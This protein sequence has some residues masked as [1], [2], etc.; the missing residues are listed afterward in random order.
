M[1]VT[2]EPIRILLV[3]DNPGDA[4]VLQDMLG[5][6]PEPGCT[7]ASRGS[8][9][10]AQRYLHTEPVDV[11]LLDLGL[12]DAYGFEAL[13]GIEDLIRGTPVVV[14][15]ALEDERVTRKA[16]ELGAQD[17]LVKGRFDADLLFRSIRYAMDR[18]RGVL[19]TQV[20]TFVEAQTSKFLEACPIGMVM[21]GPEGRIQEANPAFMELL[22][23]T[24]E[25]VE[26]GTLHWETLVVEADREGHAKALGEIQAGRGHATWEVGLL[27]KDGG[28]LPMQL[29]G[30]RLE[31]PSAGTVAYVMPS[32]ERPDPPALEACQDPVTGLKSREA[33]ME[34]LGP[35]MASSHRYG[36]PLS[37]G[38]YDLDG[39]KD[40]NTRYGQPVGDEVLRGL[41]AVLSRGI[42]GADVA[43]RYGGDEFCVLFPHSSASQASHGLERIQAASAGTVFLGP[44]GTSFTVTATFGLVDL[45]SGIKTPE[46]LFQLADQ[47]LDRAKDAGRNK[48]ESGS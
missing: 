43:A 17:F 9:S 48:V 38:L 34:I 11:V 7:L 30:A 20:R 33:F 26:A 46:R 42:R 24:P 37:L 35:A 18:Q 31:D 21:A 16:L 45:S 4:R 2:S 1:K 40:I 14:I 44:Q 25:D 23:Y 12:P 32:R 39:F 19:E 36:H 29:G 5:G 41:A 27:T 47:A 10:A 15:T 3:E 22:G 28:V 8:L 6:L 13:G